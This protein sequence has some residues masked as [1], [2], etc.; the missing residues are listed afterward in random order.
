MQPTTNNDDRDLQA[1]SSPAQPAT[2]PATSRDAAI[3]V[4]RS[5]IDTIYNEPQPN[6]R[7]AAAHSEE[8]A[9]PS[10]PYEQTHS[11]STDAQAAIDSEAVKAHWAQ[12][13]S[14]W[15]QYYQMYYERYYQNEVQKRLVGSTDVSKEP[16]IIKTPV[17]ET[18]SENQ[19]VSE[20]RSEL[21]EKV[22]KN[23]RKIRSSRHFRPAL[24]AVSVA[25][26]FA[27][28]QYN[29]LLFASVMAFT[30]PA[31]TDSSN[32][33][34]DPSTDVAVSQDPVLKI[35]KINVEAP[36]DYS[37]NTLEES[38]VQSKLKGGVV[39]YPIAGAS[40]VPGEIGN[41]VILGHSAND[42]FDDGN[43]KFI[44]LHLDRLEKGD[45]FYL[46][47]QGKRYTYS[48]TE[49]KIIDPSEVSQLV[50]NNGKPM[51]TLV[52]CTPAG[53]ALKRLLII[54]EQIAPDPSGATET[55]T[56]NTETSDQTQIGGGTQGFFERLFGG[57]F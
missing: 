50:L 2:P 1:S 47:Y 41:T 54:G 20:L 43:Y 21:L 5:Q 28:L 25:L 13:H 38:V 18:I 6:E 30:V 49:K 44:F 9:V 29:Q 53:T 34:V 17:K 14:Q 32:S 45:T 39:H 31:S 24:V 36:V 16:S 37:L 4:M 3:N 56:A 19:A 11:N 51:A 52:T 55:D 26:V 48:V 22:K 42:V 7:I 33:Y 8:Q 57:G 35:P 23:G 15:Q 12:Y 46:N 27:F 40:S 10:D